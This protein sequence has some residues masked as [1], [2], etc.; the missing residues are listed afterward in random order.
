MGENCAKL[1]AAVASAAESSF[2]AAFATTAAESAAVAASDRCG[3]LRCHFGVSRCGSKIRKLPRFRIRRHDYGMVRPRRDEF[4]ERIQRRESVHRQHFER[5]TA[6]AT[7]MHNMFYQASA[8]NQDIGDWNT[9]QVTDMIFMF[10]H[11]SAFNQDIGSWNTEK[12]TTMYGMFYKARAFNQD[13]GSWN[14]A[15]VT[16]IIICFFRFCVQSLHW[17]LEY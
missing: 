11:A 12:V 9:A 8:F 7:S 5:N 6:S 4:C 14:T 3:I 13:I 1:F 15:Q 2:A 10:G 16:T 17:R